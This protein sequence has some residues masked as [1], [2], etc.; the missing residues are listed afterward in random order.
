MY[1]LIYPLDVF[2]LLG[3]S[4][5]IG[6]L[7]GREGREGENPQNKR[8]RKQWIKQGEISRRSRGGFSCCMI[9]VV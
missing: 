7:G 6:N 1:E 8:E 5:G 3:V 2:L 9:T 4:S